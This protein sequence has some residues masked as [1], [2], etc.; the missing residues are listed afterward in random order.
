MCIMSAQILNAK[1]TYMHFYT[2]A[3]CIYTN[4]LY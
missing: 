3:K 2:Y 4:D 1:Y